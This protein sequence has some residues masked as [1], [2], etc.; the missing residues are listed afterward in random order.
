LDPAIVV[1]AGIPGAD[2]LWAAIDAEC[3]RRQ[4]DL[5]YVAG[6]ATLSTQRLELTVFGS[7]PEAESGRGVVVRRG[8]ANVVIAL[9]AV[10][11]PVHGQ[12]LIFNGDPESHAPELLVTSDNEP[13]TP[14]QHEVLVDDRRAVRLVLDTDSVRVLGGVLR[15]PAAP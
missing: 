13:R 2:P 11:P 14:L 15:S 5:R 1:V 6:R 8:N 7:P 10:P 9:G 12:A 3:A 4:I